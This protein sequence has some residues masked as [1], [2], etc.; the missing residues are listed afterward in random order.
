ML[1]FLTYVLLGDL[2]DFQELQGGV[3]VLNERTTLNISASLISDLH[4]E[5]RVTVGGVLQD[6]PV[7]GGSQV[8]NV[9]DE[10][11]FLSLGDVLIQQARPGK[12]RVQITV[13]W[14]IP[15]LEGAVGVGEEWQHRILR[16]SGVLRLVELVDYDVLEVLVLPHD[17]EGIGV[18]VERVHEHQGHLRTGG[19]VKML[20]NVNPVHK[21]RTHLDLF[22]G[23]V[24]EGLVV[25]HFDDGLRALAA[26]AGSKTTIKLEHDE[27][28]CQHSYFLRSSFCRGSQKLFKC[29]TYRR[30]PDRVSQVRPEEAQYRPCTS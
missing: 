14:R 28:L 19:P 3:S 1:N 10:E 16:D 13:A 2:G 23:K 24:Q 26:H 6:S 15:V 25:S 22:H 17:L 8:V 4:D 27:L 29:E 30:C 18:G 7:D 12:G 11:P 20:E 5:V 21:E 9:G